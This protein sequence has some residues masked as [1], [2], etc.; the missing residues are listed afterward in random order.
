MQIHEVCDRRCK[1]VVKGERQK[2]IVRVRTTPYV[3][4]HLI[5]YGKRMYINHNLDLVMIHFKPGFRRLPA[6]PMLQNAFV[7]KA[8]HRALFSSVCCKQSTTQC[9]KHP[10][11]EDSPPAP[12]SPSPSDS[13]TSRASL[14]TSASAAQTEPSLDAAGSPR[15]RGAAAR[16]PRF[17]AGFSSSPARLRTRLLSTLRSSGSGSRAPEPPRN[18][19]SS[20]LLGSQTRDLPAPGTPA[21]RAAHSTAN[22]TNR[23]QLWSTKSS[24]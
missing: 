6:V 9:T 14:A 24:G 3:Q 4:V 20:A 22:G 17:P 2:T 11:S 10:H 15:L 5:R 23:T 21:E 16:S 18:S 8:L 19:P 12:A 7:E 1:K 13:C